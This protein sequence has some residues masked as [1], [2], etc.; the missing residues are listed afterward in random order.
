MQ[1]VGMAAVLVL[2][3]LIRDNA[4]DALDVPVTMALPDCSSNRYNSLTGRCGD[5]AT[6]VSTATT[7]T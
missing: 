4:D 1:V 2:L 6:S 3:E 5:C 7:T